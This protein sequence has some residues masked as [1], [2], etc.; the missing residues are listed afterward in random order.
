M[1]KSE[2]NLTSIVSKSYFS[3]LCRWFVVFRYALNLQNLICS[4]KY[5]LTP[6]VY[7]TKKSRFFSVISSLR[8]LPHN[9]LS[10]GSLGT[11]INKSKSVAFA[12]LSNY[13][14]QTQEWIIILKTKQNKTTITI[15]RVAMQSRMNCGR[16][17][18]TK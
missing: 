7:H 1:P 17:E 5:I 8:L 11:K 9:L 14:F 12:A 15:S 18:D 13:N 10:F 3:V 6:L 2:S 4:I 16:N